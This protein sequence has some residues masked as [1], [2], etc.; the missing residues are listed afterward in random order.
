MILFIQALLLRL[1]VISI[2]Y[3]ASDVKRYR[4]GGVDNF[5]KYFLKAFIGVLDIAQISHR[6]RVMTSDIKH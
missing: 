5:V 2:I 4:C 3:I 1:Y 6:Y